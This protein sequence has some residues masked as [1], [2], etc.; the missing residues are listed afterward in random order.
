VTLNGYSENGE[1]KLGGVSSAQIEGG[2][3]KMQGRKP[4]EDSG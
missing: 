2:E 3:G 1:K 4:A